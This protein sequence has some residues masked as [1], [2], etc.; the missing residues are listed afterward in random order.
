LL[1]IQTIAAFDWRADDPRLA[2][3]LETQED[4]FLFL[5]NTSIL[6]TERQKK[7]LSEQEDWFWGGIANALGWFY[8]T[9][10]HLVRDDVPAFLRS[11]VNNYAAFVCPTPNGEYY[12][13]EGFPETKMTSTGGYPNS[14]STAGFIRNFRNLL[15]M[16]IDDALW[17]ARA[18]PRAWLEQ[19]KRIS[20]K[21]APTPF[22]TVAY[23]IVSDVDNGKISATIEM[24]TRKAPKEV[25]LRFRHP[26]SAP[27]KGV[28]V[29]G[30][31]WTEFNK[32]K[33]TITLKDLTGT[34][35]VTAQY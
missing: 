10:A 27:I 12:F 17:F 3:A 13:A 5:R 26:K 2:G 4:A 31:P 11:W 29:N 8:L 24:P 21:N 33:E 9:D 19:G 16:E 20:V 35:T 23:E 34:V 1:H 30:K 18:T 14:N 6:A 15:V 7:G 22:G 25:V 32:D 28:I